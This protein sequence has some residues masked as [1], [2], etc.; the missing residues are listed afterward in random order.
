[1]HNNEEKN[2]KNWLKTEFAFVSR[3]RPLELSAKTG[4]WIFNTPIHFIILP[5]NSGTIHFANK[6]NWNLWLIQLKVV[7][8]WNPVDL[9]TN[10][11]Y[12]TPYDITA[13]KTRISFN[14]LFKISFYIRWQ[15]LCF[16]FLVCNCIHM[17]DVNSNVNYI[18]LIV[19]VFFVVFILCWFLDVVS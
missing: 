14:F 3:E 7:I 2:H 5:L 11:T 16:F 9:S 6:L 8:C 15:R 10:V 12:G 4:K 1:M 13:P 18:C 19:A 17:I